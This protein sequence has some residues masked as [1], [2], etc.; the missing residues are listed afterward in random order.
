M[1]LRKLLGSDDGGAQAAVKLLEHE[2]AVYL[3]KRSRELIELLCSVTVRDH[4]P[5][6][7]FP[8]PRPLQAMRLPHCARSH[9]ALR[10]FWRARRRANLP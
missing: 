10:N 6:H 4:L 1:A 9:P 8:Y 7:S 5:S 2:D 3:S